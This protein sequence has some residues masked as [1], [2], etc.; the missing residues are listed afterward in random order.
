MFRFVS[1]TCFILLS[2][3]IADAEAQY[4]CTKDGK[5]TY[6][7]KPCAD[8]AGKGASQQQMT[9]AA[10]PN[11][12]L[13]PSKPA[14]R[15]NMGFD[16]SDVPG[17]EL[18]ETSTRAR[19]RS[20]PPDAPAESLG[21]YARL[22]GRTLKSVSCDEKP[23]KYLV[24]LGKCKSQFASRGGQCVIEELSAVTTV[25]GNYTTALRVEIVFTV[26]DASAPGKVHKDELTNE[27]R[28]LGACKPGMKRGE[29]FFVKDNGEWIT[30]REFEQARTWP[31]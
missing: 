9:P 4:K 24:D 13:D 1:V 31:K 21:I 20:A 3:H 14:A 2:G 17:V 18:W 11:A 25:T 8:A 5:V 29:K 27:Y 12:G 6:S 23:F 28:Y 10:P 19:R 22:G 16:K 7:D 15:P 30:W 26:P